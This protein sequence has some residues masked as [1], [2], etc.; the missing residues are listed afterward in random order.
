MFGRL[1]ENPQRLICLPLMNRS[2]CGDCRRNG[3]LR[4]AVNEEA[5]WTGKGQ[6]AEKIGS[7]IR[8]PVVAVGV[9][10]ISA[11]DFDEESLCV[12]TSYGGTNLGKLDE[13]GVLEIGNCVIAILNY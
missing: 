5:Y 12:L 9:S 7:G 11:C 4:G 6:V 2:S 3:L 13:E 1:G 8:P 10:A